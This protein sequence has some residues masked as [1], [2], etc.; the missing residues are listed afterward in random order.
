MRHLMLF[1]LSFAVIGCAPKTGKQVPVYIPAGLT[2]AAIAETLHC[3][4]IIDNPLKFLIEAR[5]LGFGKKLRYGQY[6]FALNSDELSVLQRMIQH[7][8]TSVK[9]TI[10]EGLGITQ[11]A[12]LLEIRGICRAQ[13]FISAGHDRPLLL[14]FD[15][16]FNS[17]E[18]FLFPDTYEFELKTRP[19]NV[20]KRMVRHFFEVFEELKKDAEPVLDDKQT[21]ILASIVQKEALLPEEFPVIS[22]VF[23]NR[24]NRKMLLQSC[25]TVEYILPQH[26]EKLTI[27]DTRIESPY[28]TYI[29]EGLPPGPICNP[30]RR[31]L[32]AAISPAH[33][34]YLYFVS[35][36]DGSH[37]FSCTGREN[38]RAKRRLLE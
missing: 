22:G 7:G 12:D 34:A 9:V 20:I 10:P 21:V 1:M 31:A 3:H 4:G 2:T 15:I 18:G 6:R 23:I 25:A 13:E 27:Y 38:E 36:G 19:A 35:K 14:E 17:A 11:I 29:H 32:K 37:I 26:K 16:P 5:I 8:R 30:G 28:N 33:T 24:L